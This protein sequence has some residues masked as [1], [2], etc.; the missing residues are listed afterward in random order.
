MTFERPEE[1]QTPR[2]SKHA[3][4]Q[5]HAC[6][7]HNQ[8]A[9]QTRQDTDY[10]PVTICGRLT[11]AWP[12][13]LWFRVLLD[14]VDDLRLVPRQAARPQV[15]H[16]GSVLARAQEDGSGGGNNGRCGGEG[17]LTPHAGP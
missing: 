7:S 6:T 2:N 8:K 11:C 17:V 10:A 13:V 16:E 12:R 5:P 1:F 15:C 9:M 4:Q 14:Q 3:P